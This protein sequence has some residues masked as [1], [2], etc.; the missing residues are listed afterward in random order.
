MYNPFEQTDATFIVLRN[1]QQQ[2]SLWPSYVPIPGGW[3]SQFGPSSKDACN[4]YIETNW[5]DLRPYV[6]NE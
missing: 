6:P 2:F 1:E 3:T 4:D 5:T